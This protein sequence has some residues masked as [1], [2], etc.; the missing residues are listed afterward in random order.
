ML[1]C[2]RPRPCLRFALRNSAGAPGEFSRDARVTST[3]PLGVTNQEFRVDCG[4]RV[5]RRTTDVLLGK[6][7]K[8]SSFALRRGTIA[9]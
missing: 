4:S 7:M 1:L 8:D 6:L 9:K 3:N 5:F 2:A